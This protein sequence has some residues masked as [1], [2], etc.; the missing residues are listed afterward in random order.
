MLEGKTRLFPP[1]DVTPTGPS[2]I[3]EEPFFNPAMGVN[4][5]L[6]VL[7]LEHY[8]STRGRGIDFADVLAGTGA[9]SVRIAN[10]VDGDID[11]VA[12][13]G[14][15]SACDLIRK[16]AK[17]NGVEVEI[18]N[19]N[20]H[21]FLSKRRFDAVDV[22]PF[23]SPMP[24]VDAAVNATRHNGILFLTATDTAALSG[25]FKNACRR[26]YGAEPF[27][28][29]PWRQ[30]A[31]LRILAACGIRAAGRF[32][33]AAEPL[34]SVSHEH[35]MRVALR[36]TDGKKRADIAAKS[37]G[38]IE[39]DDRGCGVRGK[40]GG[41]FYWGPLHNFSFIH[42]MVDVARRKDLSVKFVETLAAEADGA[43]FWVPMEHLARTF[44]T[45][46]VRRDQFMEK[47]PDATPT[48]LDPQGIRT[49]ATL[50]ELRAAW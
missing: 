46:M 42:G 44:G 2:A 31:G 14:D 27:H 12:N 16:T 25:T 38:G 43:P 8:A 15:P 9:R 5:D 29:A 13:D 34:F 39:V 26:R 35:W 28:G 32:D 3:G 23:G 11:V 41:P 22:D 20:A 6:S 33:R 50:D 4:R 49:R 10:E 21:Q 24:F 18:S 47:I 40:T 48:H 37:I 7:A 30:E 45:D 19:E 17:T 36:V 1:S